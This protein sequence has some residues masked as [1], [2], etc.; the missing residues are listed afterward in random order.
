MTVVQG[1]GPAQL[2]WWWP[3]VAALIGASVPTF[4]AWWLYRVGRKDAAAEYRAGRRDSVDKEAREIHRA[5]TTGPGADARA[6][7][8]AA[9][10][11]WW[12]NKRSLLSQ[13]CAGGDRDVPDGQ[14]VSTGSEADPEA[15]FQAWFY[16][17]GASLDQLVAMLGEYEKSGGDRSLRY[18]R[19]LGW[20]AGMHIAWMTWFIGAK[21][22]AELSRSPSDVHPRLSGAWGRVQDALE[23][24]GDHHVECRKPDSAPDDWPVTIK[25]FARSELAGWLYPPAS[26]EKEGVGTSVFKREKEAVRQLA[27]EVGLHLQT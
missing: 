13:E 15:D 6:F 24:V 11:E 3:V 12:K 16:V 7:F 25:D 26:A 14:A 9:E 23:A 22:V 4:V 10:Y 21:S 1:G 17:L 27:V 5:V 19:L 2:W 18:R 20:H 8:S